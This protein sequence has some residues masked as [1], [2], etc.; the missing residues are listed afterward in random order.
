MSPIEAETHLSNKKLN[1]RTGSFFIT[2]ALATGEHSATLIV[3]LHGVVNQYKVY[4]RYILQQDGGIT[5][6]S[7]DAD[8]SKNFLS[9]HDLLQNYKDAELFMGETLLTPGVMVSKH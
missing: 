1:N 7:L 2:K 4:S 9:I 6:V 3:N 8:F 5:E